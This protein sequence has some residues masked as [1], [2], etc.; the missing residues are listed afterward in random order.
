MTLTQSRG[1][2]YSQDRVITAQAVFCGRFSPLHRGHEAVIE[3]ML[4]Q[5]GP[6]HSVIVIGSSNAP[7][8]ERDF[9]SAE[10]RRFVISTVFPEVRVVFAPDYKSDI[11]WLE[12][13]DQA[14]RTVNIDPF[15]AVYFA[16]SKEDVPFFFRAGRTVSLVNRYDGTTPVISGTDVRIALRNGSPI[17]RM[18]SRTVAQKIQDLFREKVKK[19]LI[20]E[21]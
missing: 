2:D 19:K 4:H 16:G 12:E 5:F 20:V 13:L 11:Q 10:E 21:V 7:I 3:R 8:S 14:V 6:D 17:D 1:G 18:V 9:F 15:N